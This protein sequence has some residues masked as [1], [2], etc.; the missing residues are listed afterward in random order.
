M[1]HI[2]NQINTYNIIPGNTQIY[3]CRLLVFRIGWYVSN[4]GFS[5]YPFLVCYDMQSRCKIPSRFQ[6]TDSRNRSSGYVQSIEVNNDRWFHVD[7]RLW[8]CSD[9]TQYVSQCGRKIHV[10]PPP[11][12]VAE[13][14]AMSGVRRYRNDGEGLDDGCLWRSKGMGDGL[15]RGVY[16]R[17]TLE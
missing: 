10:S 7:S 15:S 12:S 1:F 3:A 9:V 6:N 17:E 2:C 13:G 14:W 5:N 16:T 11:L 4:E 8:L